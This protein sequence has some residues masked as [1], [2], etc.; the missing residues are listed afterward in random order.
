MDYK[1]DICYILARYI[2]ANPYNICKKNITINIPELLLWYKTN[3]NLINNCNNSRKSL[4]TISDN[5]I[6][7]CN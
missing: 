3:P 5:V 6:H 7:I 1:T 2:S 4:K